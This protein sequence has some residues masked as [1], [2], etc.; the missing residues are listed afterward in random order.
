MADFADMLGGFEDSDD[1][2]KLKKKQDTKA[3]IP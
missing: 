2:I 1:E 3:L